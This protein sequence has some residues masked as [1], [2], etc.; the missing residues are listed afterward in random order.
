MSV[1]WISLWT[2]ECWQLINNWH[3]VDAVRIWASVDWNSCSLSKHVL[4]CFWNILFQWALI[5]EP[6]LYLWKTPQISALLM[7]CTL[8]VLLVCMEINLKYFCF[9]T[10][11]K[12]EK[13][14]WKSSPSSSLS[15]AISIPLNPIF[16]STSSFMLVEVI[17][18]SSIWSLIIRPKQFGCMYQPLK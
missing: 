12:R 7:H 10:K 14:L 5:S 11:M 4:F 17:Q 1:K 6:H 2:S 8:F 3:A 15:C 18:S 13:Y 9:S 16:I